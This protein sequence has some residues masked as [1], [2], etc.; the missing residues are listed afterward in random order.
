VVAVDPSGS[1]R[2]AV[3][4]WLPKGRR[5]S[6]RCRASTARPRRSAPARVVKNALR[7]TLM[8]T[9]VEQARDRRRM[10]DLYVL[11]AQLPDAD[12]LKK[13]RRLVAR[14]RDPCRHL[15]DERTHRAASVTIVLLCPDCNQPA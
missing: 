1:F 7:L 3:R 14:D 5:S 6:T 9:T 13:H 11:G 15:S 10:L 2:S 12:R 4:R 8:S